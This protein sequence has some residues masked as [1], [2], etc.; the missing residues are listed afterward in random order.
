MQL[1]QL[2]DKLIVGHDGPF[3]GDSHRERHSEDISDTTNKPYHKHKEKENVHFFSSDAVHEGPLE[4]AIMA[5]MK[6]L[7][8][9]SGT[10]FSLMHYSQSDGAHHR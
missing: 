2:L 10:L 4:L 1:V 7:K 3:N 9:N 6:Q 8:G 5:S